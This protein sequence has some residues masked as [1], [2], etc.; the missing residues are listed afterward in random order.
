MS[1]R[2]SNDEMDSAHDACPFS[3]QDESGEIKAEVY[4]AH[5]RIGGWTHVA[6]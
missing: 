5:G 3:M 4:D 6:S 2:G 1:M